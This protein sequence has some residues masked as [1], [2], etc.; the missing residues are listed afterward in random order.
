MKLEKEALE[1][2]LKNAATVEDIITVRERLTDVIYQIES[3]ESQLR[4][5]DNLVSYTTVTMTVREVERT[6]VVEKQ[7]IWQKIGT[8]LK[9]NFIIV[10]E[11]LVGVFVFFISAIPY[12]ILIGAIVFVF[13]FLH[14]IKKRKKLKKQEEKK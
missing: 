11:I 1:E 8:N 13:V 12:F 6:S 9:E 5:Y 10:W 4:T 3:Y 2:L 14:R 7:G